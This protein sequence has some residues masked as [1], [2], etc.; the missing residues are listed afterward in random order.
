LEH[1]VE[2]PTAPAPAAPLPVQP[3]LTGLDL[4]VAG[5]P[6]S[7]PVPAAAPAAAARPAPRQKGRHRYWSIR[8]LSRRLWLGRGYEFLREAI[9]SG[10]LPASRSAHSWWVDDADV[11]GLQAAFDGRAG[12]VRAFRRLDDW[13]RDRCWVVP[14]SAET[15]SL[16]HREAGSG[17]TPAAVFHWRGVAYLPRSVWQ[18]EQTP[19]GVVYRHRADGVVLPGPAARA[20]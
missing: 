18:A 11:L 1:P 19:E 4:G 3:T 2:H 15:L 14:A 17:R 6:A 5:R 12:K 8:D 9:R 16:G 7:A 20:A 13:L 10:V